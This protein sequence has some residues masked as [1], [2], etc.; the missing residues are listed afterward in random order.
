MFQKFRSK[1]AALVTGLTLA[2]AAPFAFAGGGGST[3]VDVSAVVSAIEGAAA[4]I[5]AIGAAVLI[6]MVGIK[7]YKWVRR[8]M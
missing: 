1:F 3:G 2:L 5:A 7:V 8:A 6:V 4:P